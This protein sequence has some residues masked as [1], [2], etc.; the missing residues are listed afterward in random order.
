MPSDSVLGTKTLREVAADPSRSSIFYLAADQAI[1][2]ELKWKEGNTVKAAPPHYR[3]MVGTI[4]LET[5]LREPDRVKRNRYNEI[6]DIRVGDFNRLSKL[7]QL[8]Q[9]SDLWDTCY[10]G[11]ALS[12]DAKAMVDGDDATTGSGSLPSS[13]KPRPG[14]GFLTSLEPGPEPQAWRKYQVGFRIEGGRSKSGKR[15]DLDRVSREGIWPLMKQPDLAVLVVKKFYHEHKIAKAQELY[16]GYQNRDLYNESGTCVARS[17]LGATAFPYRDTHNNHSN[18]DPNL[19]GD[20]LYQYLFAV[21]CSGLKGVDTEAEQIRLRNDS[22]WRPGEK[23]FAGIPQNKVLGY[24]RVVRKGKPSH[25]NPNVLTGWAF[26][27]L[28]TSWTWLRE[29][30]GPRRIFLDTE[31]R[32]WQRNKTY[33]IGAAY[34]FQGA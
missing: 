28:D 31:L 26:E 16:I 1:L 32:A 15:D 34:D 11:V 3:N 17:L 12:T 20:L 22:L 19:G 14:N 8:Q 9:L 10:M 23:A 5:A 13:L 29:P 21:D 30:Y 18:G 27:L 25:S 4:L 24:V 7:E 6:L 33:V 2:N